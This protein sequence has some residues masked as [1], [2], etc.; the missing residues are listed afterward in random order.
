VR[1]TRKPFFRPKKEKVKKNKKEEQELE[2]PDTEDDGT[3]VGSSLPA[4]VIKE[5]EKKKKE[6][7][8]MNIIGNGLPHGMM[9]E[10]NSIYDWKMFYE[11]ILKINS[12]NYAGN[13]SL[14]WGQIKLQIQTRSL[15]ELRN[16]FIELNVQLRQ[17][18]MDEEKSFVD[19]RILMGERLLQKDY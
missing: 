9:L 16:K 14:S 5:E 2:K 7:S 4:S 18:G 17:I 3:S 10:T 11:Q 19:E 13:S 8:N 12:F 6:E 1:Q 15:E